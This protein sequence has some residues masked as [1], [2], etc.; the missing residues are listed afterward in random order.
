MGYTEFNHLY[1][2]HLSPMFLYLG[3]GFVK[4]TDK[5]SAD[6][7]L[8]DAQED[9]ITLDGRQLIVALAVSRE[10]ASDFKEKKEKEQKDKRN[11]FLAREGSE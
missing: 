6:N 9:K 5:S 3:I 11:L 8:A 2:V 10:K 7:C 4:F 1:F